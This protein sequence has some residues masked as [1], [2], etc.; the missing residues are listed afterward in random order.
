MSSILGRA[1]C[2]FVL[3]CSSL[4]AA[5]STPQ[6]P[7]FPT[8]QDRWVGAPPTWKSLRGQVVLLDVWTFG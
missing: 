7:P 5:S 2:A 3:L 4:G 8:A 1:L 6:A